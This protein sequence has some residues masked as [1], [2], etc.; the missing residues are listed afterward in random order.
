MNERKARK[1]LRGI[2]SEGL[3]RL[4]AIGLSDEDLKTPLKIWTFLKNH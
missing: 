1:I 2:S 4:N 3:K